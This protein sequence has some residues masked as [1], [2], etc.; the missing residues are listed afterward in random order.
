MSTAEQLAG[1]YQLSLEEMSLHDVTEEYAQVTGRPASTDREAMITQLVANGLPR[2]WRDVS[3]YR[4]AAVG[5]Q[6]WM[7]AVAPRATAA[8]AA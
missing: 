6:T 4:V 5:C 2:T 7:L 3:A 8:N 1:L